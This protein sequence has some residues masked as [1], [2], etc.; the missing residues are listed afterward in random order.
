M[1]SLIQ[2]TGYVFDAFKRQMLS[3]GHLA[4]ILRQMSV[5]ARKTPLPW[6]SYPA[7]HFLSTLDLANAHLFEFGSGNSTVWWGRRVLEGK[8]R[9]YAGLENV[10]AYYQVMAKENGFYRDHVR[11][12]DDSN[13][14]GLFRYLELPSLICAERGRPFDVTIV[15]GPIHHRA[16][17]LT[18]ALEITDSDGIIMVDDANWLSKEVTDFCE[19]HQM[20]HLDFA[21]PG[22]SVS[23]PKVTSFLFRDPM[24]FRNAEV[25]TPPQGMESFPGMH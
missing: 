13:E 2:R 24:W 15:D 4:S 22:P 20:Y 8:L 19:E 3:N 17:Q 5:G 1:K 14:V 12:V 16:A 18:K 25:L 6:I 9:S 21:G 11:V 23:Y 10:M 7:I